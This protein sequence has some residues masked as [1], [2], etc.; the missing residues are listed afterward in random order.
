MDERV[1]AFS[2]RLDQIISVLIAALTSKF[3]KVERR[4][5]LQVNNEVDWF[6]IVD[7]IQVQTQLFKIYL[8]F[9]GRRS[10]RSAVRNSH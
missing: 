9:R 5:A 2:V 10:I 3:T 4:G 8:R 1:E 6:A 7:A